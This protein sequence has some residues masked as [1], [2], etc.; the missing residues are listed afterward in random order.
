MLH[1]PH[2][3]V[4]VIVNAVAVDNACNA[5]TTHVPAAVAA[6]VACG[7]GVFELDDSSSGGDDNLS[8]VGGEGVAGLK[9]TGLPNLGD[10]GD[11]DVDPSSPALTS[12]GHSQGY[13]NFDDNDS[14]P[15]AE[16]TKYW[17]FNCHEHYMEGQ[18]ISLYNWKAV[19]FAIMVEAG[20]TMQ[21]MDPMKKEDCAKAFY[22]KYVRIID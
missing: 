7:R 6:N 8:N 15:D 12:Y 14:L 13:G 4:A 9:T 2:V 22:V 20:T 10:V 19:E 17:F 21:N 18:K 16:V 5:L 1:P 3:F 11:D